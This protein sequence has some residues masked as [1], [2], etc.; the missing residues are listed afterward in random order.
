MST[1]PII[2]PQDPEL[3]NDVKRTKGFFQDPTM[4][5]MARHF[6]TL[7]RYFHFESF[8]NSSEHNLLFLF[9]NFHLL[10]FER[11][12]ENIIIPRNVGPVKILTNE[13]KMLNSFFDS[14]TFKSVMACVL[15]YGLGGAIGLFSSS[16]NP[17]ISGGPGV[18]TRQ[19]AKEIFK[20]MRT[21]THG[22]AKNFALIGAVFSVVECTIET[23]SFRFSF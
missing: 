12:R 1:L 21:T 3:L 14:C 15:G 22:Y 23:V 20:E 10:Y 18:E 6:I 16:V 2:S 4:D 7:H 11:Y 13:E 9:S 5:R 19:S 17:N 8:N